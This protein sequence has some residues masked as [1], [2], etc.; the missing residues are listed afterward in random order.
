[1]LGGAGCVGGAHEIEMGEPFFFTL[2]FATTVGELSELVG[3]RF[4]AADADIRIEG[5]APIEA[6]G[7]RQLAYIDNPRYLAALGATRAAAC[8]M[9]P[10]M[11]QRAPAGVASILVDDPYRAFARIAAHLV[12]ASLRSAPLF[13]AG[14]SPKAHVDP[15]ARLEPGVDVEPGAVVGAAVEIGTGTIIGA[16]AVIGAGVRIGRDCQ[17]GAGASVFCALLGDRVILH[18]GVRIGQDG[19][20]F[21][22]GDKGHAKVPQMGRVIIQDDVEIGANSTVDRGATRDT[23]VGEGAK[24][25]NLVQIGHN[26]I[27]GRHCVIVA[28]TGIAGST[29]LGDFVIVG[30]QT[31]IAGHLEIGR[32]A[33]IAAQSGV[34]RDVRAGASVGGSPAQELRAFL[35]QAARGRR[36]SKREIKT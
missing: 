19:F 10:A 17:I 7:P 21:A 35:Q 4:D 11:A 23:I 24:I 31:G 28:Q 15:E 16:N 22:L 32:G 9:R 3:A 29:E 25:D 34:M 18:P 26:V 14:L 20:G 13:G 2:S 33:R 1:V 6:A 30:G 12:P 36:P 8:L 27:V 5:L